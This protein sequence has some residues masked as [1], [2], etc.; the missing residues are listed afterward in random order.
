MK[1]IW[2]EPFLDNPEIFVKRYVLYITSAANVE[3][4][5]YKTKK[6]KSRFRLIEI[7]IDYMTFD[8]LPH[9]TINNS[10]NKIVK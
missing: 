3:R 1:T 4:M 10:S 6:H 2:K 5:V 9:K 8:Y 7:E